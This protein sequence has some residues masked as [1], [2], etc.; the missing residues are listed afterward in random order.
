MRLI[1]RSECFVDTPILHAQLFRGERRGCSCTLQSSRRT[2]AFTRERKS[3]TCSRNFVKLHR[4]IANGIANA[5][6]VL[7]RE[8]GTEGLLE[9]KR[10]GDVPCSRSCCL[11]ITSMKT[12]CW[13]A[14]STKYGLDRTCFFAIITI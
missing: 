6:G 14:I 10:R 5:L 12:P 3:R 8:S 1:D 13:P 2:N 7:S 9:R 11:A 4:L